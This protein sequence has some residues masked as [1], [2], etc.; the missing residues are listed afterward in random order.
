MR[1]RHVL[2]AEDHFAA[3]IT[4][5]PKQDGMYGFLLKLTDR[6]LVT[7]GEDDNGHPS[8]EI[9]GF[10]ISE[11]GYQAADR[12]GE[13]TKFMGYISLS[14]LRA[15]GHD[16]E[17]WLPTYVQTLR[18]WGETWAARSRPAPATLFKEPEFLQEE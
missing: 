9:V 6:C 7:R 3:Y 12:V 11:D 1:I 2:P 5:A 16:P 18:S 15:M 10:V 8:D 17:K 13:D 14:N 4:R